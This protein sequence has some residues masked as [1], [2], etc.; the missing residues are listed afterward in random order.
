MEKIIFSGIQPTGGI[1]L[2]NYLGAIKQWVDLQEEADRAIFCIVD[3]HAITMPQDPAE[4]QKNILDLAAIYLAAGIDPE[5]S[6][7]FVQ[8]SRPEHAELSWI[9]NCFTSMGE[10]NRMTQ[11]KDKSGDARD[12]VSAGLFDY[13]VLMAADILLYKA[14]HVPVGHDQKQHV[15]LT[16]NIAQRFNGK[17][18]EVF[19]LPEPVIKSSSARI[20]GLDN[21]L[22]K[23]SKSAASANNFIA[24]SDSKEQ[25]VDKIK[26]AVTDS[27]NE[28]KAG[29]DKP[30]IT[31][32]LNIFAEVTGRGITD[33]ENEFKGKGY[34]EF[35]N[36]LADAI[37]DFLSPIQEKSKKYSEN[38]NELITILK[39][40]AEAVAPTAQETLRIVQQK[41][42]LGI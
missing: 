24:L 15:E 31:N 36:K 28:I 3:L 6:T 41:V 37:I 29:P 32:L 38:K 34:G 30:A 7:L 35:K 1:H 14:T 25:I 21:P 33:I 22:K 40:G 39:N 23:M 11:F 20:M 5:K 13:P 12:S 18:G 4:L 27:G 26:K 19:T 42:G 8:S 2:G 10:L 16:R 17:F 9:L